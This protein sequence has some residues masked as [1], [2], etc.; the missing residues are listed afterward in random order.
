MKIL[1]KALVFTLIGASAVLVACSKDD[2]DKKTTNI[3]SRNGLV[4]SP[5]NERPVVTT[6]TA[7]GTANVSFD[8]TTKVLTYT[9]NWSGLSDSLT[10]S[11]IHGTSSKEASSG[12]KVGFT[13]PRGSL[14]GNYSGTAQVDGVLI[15]EDSLLKGFYYF[16]LHT[17]K[18]PGGEIRAQI[19]F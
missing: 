7:T 13:L 18:N 12:V 19:E 8:K 1:K 16:N 11:H 15:K 2:D 10:G 17:K 5:A 9:L 4:F 14:S 3:A 6:S